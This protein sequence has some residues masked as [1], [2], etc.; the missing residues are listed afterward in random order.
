MAADD[1][2][3]FPARVRAESGGQVV[4][5]DFSDIRLDIPGLELFVPPGSF[6]QYASAAALI[7]E[8]MIRESSHEKGP[9]GGSNP[10]GA[11]CQLPSDPVIGR[12]Q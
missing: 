7:N 3:R 6:T 11:A 12:P 4:T 5:V 8:L 10:R 9:S 1:L 2:K